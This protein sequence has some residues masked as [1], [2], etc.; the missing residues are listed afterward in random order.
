MQNNEWNAQKY[1]QFS[2]S[3]EKWAKE[4]IEDISIDETTSILDIG[5]GDGKVTNLF[6]QQ[7]AKEV[8]GIDSS[9]NMIVLA[10]SN[11]KEITF[12]VMDAQKIEFENKFDL[13]FSNAALHWVKNHEAVLQGVY[14]SL[15]PYGKI[16]FQMGGYGNAA[17]IFQAL[18]T[19]KQ[20]YSQYFR[21]FSSP[22]TFHTDRYYD[23]LLEKYGFVN[24]KVALIKKDM[25]HQDRKIFKGWLE[26]TWF[27]YLNQVPK[28]FQEHFLEQ[29]IENYLDIVPLDLEKRVHVSMVRLEVKAQKGKLNL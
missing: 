19:T 29:W 17:M 2:K 27:P 16:V 1:K 15:K 6:Y 21:D 4:L 3:Q 11:Y 28:E 13:V 9:S 20:K 8:I 22:Y 23:A 7:S 25:I 10:K 18:E 5:C 24:K 26:T 12:I 14:K